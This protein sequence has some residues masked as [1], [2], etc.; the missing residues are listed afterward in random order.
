[1]VEVGDEIEV[2]VLKFDR[3]RNRVSLGLKQL[4]EDPWS[5]IVARYPRN[6]RVPATVTNLTDYGCFAELED[7]VEGLVHVSEMDW[8]NKNVHPSKVVQIGDRI[9]VMILDIDEERR[10]ISL[11]MK[12]C[13]P[14]PWEEFGVHH[15]KNEVIRGTIK[16]ITDFGV[17]IGLEGGIDGLVHLS[18]ISW[19]QTGEEAIRNFH[20]GDEIETVIL[21][22]DPE[23]ERISLGIKQLADD[24]FSNYVARNDKGSVVKGVVREVDAKGAVID[25]GDDIE[26]QLKASE[27]SRDRVEDARNALS[28]GD[29]VEAQIIN[30]DR[31]SRMI[32]LSIKA[33]E[34][35]EERASVK[36]HKRQETEAMPS[37]TIGDL[38]RA[39]M[40]SA[41]R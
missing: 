26:A 20:K 19:N 35:S 24:P 32:N 10:R 11:G 16:S 28:V 29:E 41:D 4:G 33:K 23:R 36:E 9:E 25:L 30:V 6:A 8:T 12:Q 5:D 38:I 3:E 13:L 1:M 40:D 27:I 18:D 37:T 14:N 2:K 39:Q 21:A 7:G 22:I 15:A 34:S 31:K 17:F